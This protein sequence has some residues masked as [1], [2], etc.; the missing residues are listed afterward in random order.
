MKTGIELIAAERQEQIEKHGRTIEMD[1]LTNSKGQLSLAAGILSQKNIP[2]NFGL[3]PT[4]W[5][6]ET[7]DKIIKKEYNQ[8]LV[9]AGAL[10]AAEIDRLKA[11][12]SEINFAYLDLTNQP[13]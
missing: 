4:G 10:I 9:I 1:V 12:Q 6:Y 5:D 11:M 3:I 2:S 8:R 13:G 7:W